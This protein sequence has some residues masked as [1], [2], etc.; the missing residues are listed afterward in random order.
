SEII[1]Y[2]L[3]KDE[4]EIIFLNHFNYNL[5]DSKIADQIASEFLGST[6]ILGTTDESFEEKDIRNKNEV[7]E[8]VRK[9][10]EI[11]LQRAETISI[12][13]KHKWL[14]DFINFQLGNTHQ[15]K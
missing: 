9:T 15:R 14:I 4:D 11:E 13:E 1:N 12:Q 7:M 10:S 2:M 6:G 5:I 3:V 8:N